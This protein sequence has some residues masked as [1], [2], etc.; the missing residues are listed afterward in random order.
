MSHLIFDLPAPVIEIWKAQQALAKHF[1]HTKLKFTLDGRLVGD[2][3]E[4]MALEIF[5]LSLPSGRTPGVDAWTKD[6]ERRSVQVKASGQKGSGPS[7]T[8]GE[9]VADHLLFFKFDFPAG[10]ASVEYNGPEAP[11]RQRLLPAKWTGTKSVKLKDLLTL[12]EELGGAG[13]LQVR[14]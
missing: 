13:A 2:I 5:D 14:K 1:E 12:G 9:G 3:A 7:F 10:R 8:P 6:A 11:V 4:A